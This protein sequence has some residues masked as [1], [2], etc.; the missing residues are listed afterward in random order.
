MCNAAPK[1]PPGPHRKALRKLWAGGLLRPDRAFEFGVLESRVQRTSLTIAEL[2][3]AYYH[4][5]GI[6]V[7]RFSNASICYQMA[8]LKYAWSSLSSGVSW[9]RLRATASTL[10]SSRTDCLSNQCGLPFR[11]FSLTFMNGAFAA[12]RIGDRSLALT[13]R[14][15]IIR[16]PTFC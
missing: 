13:L 16:T 10:S 8:Y 14:G 6:A 4:I 5:N 11:P 9:P 15:S 1:V 7:R 3:R 12:P 2:L